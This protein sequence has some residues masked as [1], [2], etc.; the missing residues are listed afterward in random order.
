MFKSSLHCLFHVTVN[1]YFCF[2][3]NIAF[4]LGVDTVLLIFV[5]IY[6]FDYI[7]S[8]AHLEAHTHKRTYMISTYKRNGDNQAHEL[9]WKGR[10]KDFSET[11]A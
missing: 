4:R 2:Y 8:H 11:K 5:D 10:N 3:F 7:F 9:G 1:I 6:H